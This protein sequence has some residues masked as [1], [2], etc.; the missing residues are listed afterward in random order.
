MDLITALAV[1]IGLLGG[2]ATFLFASMGQLGL[3]WIAF[4]A[5]ASF[6]HCGGE[7]KGLQASLIANVWGVVMAS[8][9]LFLI[10][11]PFLGITGNLWIAIC[12]GLGA[13]ILVLGAKLPALAAIPA[14]VYGFAST[15]GYALL[16]S[17]FD[18][19][20]PSFANPLICVTLAM[21]VGGIFGIIS[22]KVAGAITA[23]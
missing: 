13:F 3:V 8:V 9:G 23:G 5:W 19:T 2:V 15:A 4:I 14:S 10:T 12:V 17:T 11:H 16:T 21:V 1:S 7:A 22:Q 6:Y 20:M 18:V